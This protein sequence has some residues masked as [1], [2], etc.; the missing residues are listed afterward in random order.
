MHLRFRLFFKAPILKFYLEAINKPFNLIFKKILV[1]NANPK[2]RAI[3]NHGAKKKITKNKNK[4][5]LF[6]RLILGNSILQ[7][8]NFN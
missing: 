7:I 1:L 8:L 5:K 2:K 4:D 3:S 6:I